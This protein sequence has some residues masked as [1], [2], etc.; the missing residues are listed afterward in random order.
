MHTTTLP[1]A[2][3]GAGPVGL[4]AAAHL[5][6]RG[7]PF[8]V[9]EAG[10]APADH[11][12]A[13]GHVRVFS[14]WGFNTD[15]AAVRLLE[16][17]GW[18]APDPDGLPT[19]AEIVDRYLAPL[20]ALPAIAPY[21]RYGA[22]VTTVR[23]RGLDKLKSPGRGEAPF[24]VRFATPDGEKELLARAVVD[25]SGTYGT[26]N[27]LGADGVPAIGEAAAGDR[28]FYGIPDVLG[29]DR[30]RYAGKR[31]LVVG[32]G[33]S[34]MNAVLDLVELAGAA[35]RTAVTWT[36][37]RPAPGQMF[38]GGAGDQLPARGGLGAR[39]QALIAEGLVRLE[40]GFA[41]SRVLAWPDGVVLSAD[42]R[43][44]GPFDEVVAATGFRPDLEMLRE[45][46]LGLD[47]ALESPSV[48]APLIDPNVHSC[49]SVPP[50]G[51]RELAHPEPGFYL[52]GAKSYGRA[53]TVLMRTGY[54]QVRSV[55]AALA[56]DLAA[57][58]AV[59]LVLPE[60]GV[61]SSAGAA[62]EGAACCGTPAPKGRGEPLPL[63]VAA[64]RSASRGEPLPL[65]AGGAPAACCGAE[66]CHGDPSTTVGAERTCGCGSECCA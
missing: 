52:V 49:G 11:V 12:R 62:G 18:T 10:P 53:P 30:A 61:C 45:L 35:P 3:I 39:A 22:R 47:P 24:A 63:L 13:W 55:V 42:E 1:V 28:I 26:P 5:A 46:R 6:E 25:A 31:V 20:A 4:A 66:C 23:R 15:P 56:G 64:P 27:P 7:L 29:A 59:E 32:S 8:V 17:S 57:A 34:A 41:T 37:R 44:I 65:I 19:G 21:V 9:L 58:D 54:E 40:A 16:A 50:H 33:H 43:T 60:T 36:I 38:G 48:L 51:H 14:P 2:V